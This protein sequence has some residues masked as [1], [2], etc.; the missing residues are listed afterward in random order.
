MTALTGCALL[1]TNAYPVAMLPNQFKIMGQGKIGPVPIVILYFVVLAFIAWVI[2]NK[3]SFGKKLYAL[4]GSESAARVAGINIEKTKMIVYMW[5]GLVAAF[6]GIVLTA[7][8]GSGISTMG[9]GY[10]LDA[11]AA[12]VVGGVSNTGGIGKISGVVLGVLLIGMI[13]NG[14]LLLGTS[15]YVQQVVRGL[16]IVLAVLFDLRHLARRV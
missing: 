13:N 16:V 10:Q 7:R 8:S 3:T 5:S 4:G 2:L 12:C 9:D 11:V 6:S 1:Y 15:P 14:L